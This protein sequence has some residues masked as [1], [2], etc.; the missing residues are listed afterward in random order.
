M[1]KRT[2]NYYIIAK[3]INIMQIIKEKCENEVVKIVA[4]SK[5]FGTIACKFCVTTVIAYM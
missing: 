5:S 1:Y 4:T 3:T 2:S